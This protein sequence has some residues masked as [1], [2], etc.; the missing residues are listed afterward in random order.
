M[1]LFYDLLAKGYFPQEMPPCFS[2]L[3]F[4]ACCEFATNPIP[5]Q[6]TSPTRTKAT[7]FSYARG[8][9]GSMR[10]HLSILNPVNFYSIA[11]CVANNWNDIDQHLNLTHLSQ[12]RPMHWANSTR[13]LATVSY[14]KRFLVEPR[15]RNRATARVLLITDI[16]QFYHSIYTHS[17]AWG[18]HTKAVAKVTYGHHL[19]GNKLDSLVQKAQDGQTRGIPIG[20]DTSLVIAECILA[21]IEADVLARIPSIAGLRYIDDYELCFSDYGQ[22]ENALSVLQEELQRFELQ[23]NP[24][25]TKLLPPPVR[26]EPEWIGDFRTFQIRNNSG[27]HGDLVRYFDLISKY[28]AS[29][30]DEHVAKYA[31][32]KL[33]LTNFVP[34]ISNVSLYTALLCQ[35]LVSQPSA[36]KEI[37]NS[38]LAL[39]ASGNH[40]DLGLISDAFSEVIF[41]GAPLGHHY[42]VSWLLFGALTI[43]IPLSPKAVA[44]LS[45][46]D[47]SVV[48]VMAL[49]AQSR[50]LA[51]NLDLTLWAS[52][53]TTGDLEDEHWLLSFEGKIHGWLPSTGG[54]DHISANQSFNFLRSE[55]VRFYTPI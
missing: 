39:H 26:F 14:A 33:V 18:F 50:G 35:L 31:M 46:C 30:G 19:Y 10:R 34:L 2:T 9:N 3:L 5:Q 53:M 47:N 16:S 51:A 32:S 41:R 1:S 28:V 20:P 45:L 27:Q 15:A 54:G 4:S 36:T 42:E 25:K 17:I 6:F 52:H 24:K 29:D 7:S 49:N 38:L 43:G 8:G 40:L 22:A 44:A 48:A 21:R 11:D 13:A 23:L 37:V 12:S 55:G